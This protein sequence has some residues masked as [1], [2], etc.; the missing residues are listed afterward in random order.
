MRADETYITCRSWTVVKRTLDAC[1]SPYDVP[2]TPTNV[3][4]RTAV[5][6]VDK[7]DRRRD[8]LAESAVE[9]EAVPCHDLRQHGGGVRAEPVLDD[10]LVTAAQHF[11][12]QVAAV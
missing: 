9:L 6:P 8:E 10:H 11:D 1:Q 7:F 3:S 12:V 5:R 2:V 4:R